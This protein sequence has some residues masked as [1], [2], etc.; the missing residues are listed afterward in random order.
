MTYTATITKLEENEETGMAIATID[1][2]Q[3]G[4]I[5]KLGE[6]S[7]SDTIANIHQRIKIDL[8]QFTEQHKASVVVE[9]FQ[10]HFVIDD[11]GTVS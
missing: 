4:A 3:D 1:I 8:A 5:E 11:E 10:K 9:P 6:M 7:V 2:F